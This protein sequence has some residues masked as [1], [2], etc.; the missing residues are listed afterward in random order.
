MDGIILIIVITGNGLKIHPESAQSSSIINNNKPA[1]A[2]DGDHAT[3]SHTFCEYNM[4]IWFKLKFSEVY[5]FTEVII[6]NSV[7]S[8]FAW[9]MHD[10]K[11]FVKN[12]ELGTEEFCEVLKIGKYLDV[13]TYRYVHR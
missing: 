1:N 7:T 4:D 2:I 6:T 10:T 5:C 3:I 11:I 9:R 12:T 13:Y 8:T